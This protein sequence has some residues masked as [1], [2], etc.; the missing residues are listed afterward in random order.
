M[1]FCG[2]IKVMEELEKENLALKKKLEDFKKPLNAFYIVAP[3]KN[4]IDK[5]NKFL[6]VYSEVTAEKKLLPIDRKVLA[7]YIIKGIS[8]ETLELI[9]EDN[10]TYNPNAKKEKNQFNK[11]HLHGINKRLRDQGY[12][13]KNPLN[14][15]KFFLSETMELLQK[16]I[17]VDQCKGIIINL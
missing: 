1:Y 4:K 8:D 5:I 13:I 10:P 2:I 7:Y 15:Q 17:N 12:L 3:S 16:K 11:N 9:L 6:S 14:H